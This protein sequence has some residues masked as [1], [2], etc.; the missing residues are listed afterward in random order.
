MADLVALQ[1]NI[2]INLHIVAPDSKQEKVF[3]EIQRPVFSMLEGRQL[4]SM[5]TFLSYDSVR[6]IADLKYLSRVS[7]SIIEDFE[8]I[9][10]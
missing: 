4:N 9:A 7:E 2:N 10:E 6:Q 8:Q 5:C 3:Q 1:P